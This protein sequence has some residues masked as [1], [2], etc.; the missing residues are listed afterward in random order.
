MK[1][2]RKLQ[3]NKFRF[4]KRWGQNFLIDKNIINKIVNQADINKNT[5]VIEI[6]TGSGN[7]TEILSEKAKLVVS[8]EIDKSLQPFLRDRFKDKD[9]IKIIYDDFLTRDIKKDI[10]VKAGKEIVVVANLP[11]YITKP[12]INKIIELNIIKQAI[13]MMQKEVAYRL[14]MK[15]DIKRYGVMSFALAY[16]FEMKPLFLVKKEAFI[17]KPNVDSFVIKMKRKNKKLKVID[18]EFL[19]KLIKEGLKCKRKMIKNNLKNYDVTIM[20][21][22]LKENNLTM[23]VRPES[24]T[25]DIWIELANALLKVKGD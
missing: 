25:L 12:I 1:N 21:R 14:I 20:E 15:E 9:N 22:V 5:L 16:H 11:Y 8:Y 10:K 3:G 4:K 17:P 7:L 6:G 24:L 23:N 18:E 13:I 2:I 19:F